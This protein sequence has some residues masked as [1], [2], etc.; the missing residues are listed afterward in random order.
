MG[1]TGVAIVALPSVDDYVWKI[2]SEEKPHLTIL[3]LGDQV[4]D[5]DQAQIAQFLQHAA[6]TS[7]TRFGLSVSK[8]GTLGE[9]SAD[10]LFFEKSFAKDVANFRG[11]LLQ[12]ELINKAYHATPQ[13][14][15]WTPHLTLGYP[16]TPAKEDDRDYGISW[17][18]F[19]RVALWTGEYD[20]PE[21]DLKEYPMAEDVAWAE[22]MDDVLAHYGVKGMR[23]G[24][25]KDKPRGAIRRGATKANV[26]LNAGAKVIDE[27]EKKLIFLPQKNRNKAAAATQ[28]R[29]LAEAAAINR[30]AQFK[31]KDIKND[32]RLR[33]A[34]FKK[35]EAAARE[36]YAEELGIARTEAWGEFLGVDTRAATNQM[37]ITAAANRIKHADEEVEVLLELN[38][39]TDELGHIVDVKVPQKYLEHSGLEDRSEGGTTAKRAKVPDSI[40]ED[41]QA[42]NAAAARVTRKGDTSALSN[43]ELQQLVNRMNLEQQ[44][45]RLSSEPGRLKAGE[46]RAKDILNT[47]KTINEVATFAQSPLGKAMRKVMEPRFRKAAIGAAV[48]AGKAAGK[49]AR[50]RG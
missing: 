19:D 40:S 28:T 13:F 48:I 20:G 36:T 32:T 16:E 35:V 2:S 34:Y 23:W 50:A 30:S 5:S 7:L 42:A 47:G 12:N 37:R 18:N 49:I 17:V 15:G 14:D 33:N 11:F 44:Y 9:D 31:G 10:V 4:S 22:Q 21:F 27:G 8:R 24:V 29:V 43:K 6:E 46:K 38:F 39:V 1:T 45:S 25:R 26:A 41:K 3:F